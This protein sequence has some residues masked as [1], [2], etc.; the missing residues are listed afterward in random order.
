M[1]K[2][3]KQKALAKTPDQK[4]LKPSS[5]MPAH[6]V[7]AVVQVSLTAPGR[8]LEN[9]EVNELMSDGAVELY[10]RLAPKDA[11]DEIAAV[12]AVSVSNASLDCLAQAARVAPQHLDHRDLN[13]K[14]GLKGAAVAADLIRLLDSRRGQS[15]KSVSVGNVNVEAGGQA[16][17]GNVGTGPRRNEVEPDNKASAFRAKKQKTA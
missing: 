14:H 16:I 12:L 6:E 13:L 11:L 17:V 2:S 5:E 3:K 7:S 10:R 8:Y 15:S 1:E 4:H 9:R